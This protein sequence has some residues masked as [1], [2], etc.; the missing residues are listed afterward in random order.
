MRFSSCNPRSECGTIINNPYIYLF[1]FVEIK[2]IFFLPD[3]RVFPRRA[4]LECRRSFY[5]KSKAGSIR[6]EESYVTDSARPI[7]A[8]CIRPRQRKENAI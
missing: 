1:Y 3:F 8:S 2:D 6:K 5:T 4:E 7:K